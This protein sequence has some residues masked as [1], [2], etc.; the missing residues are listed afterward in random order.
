MKAVDTHT[1]GP[2]MPSRFARSGPGTLTRIR[3]A[4]AVGGTA[5]LVLTAALTLGFRSLAGES[6]P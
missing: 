5:F 3:Y 2:T 1:G 4:L 6:G